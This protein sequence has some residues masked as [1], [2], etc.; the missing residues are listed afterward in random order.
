MAG[1]NALHRARDEQIYINCPW[2]GRGTGRRGGGGRRVEGRWG[3][4]RREQGRTKGNKE[5]RERQ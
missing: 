5:R 2:E 1:I 4:G 3:V